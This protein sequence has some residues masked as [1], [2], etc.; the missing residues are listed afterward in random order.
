V[1]KFLNL[2]AMM[3]KTLRLTLK[4]RPEI[5]SELL[6]LNPDKD[7]RVDIS[8]WTSMRSHEQNK[9]YWEMLGQL[10]DHLGYT[11]DEMHQML[12][13][14]YLSYKNVVM[15]NEVVVVPSTT[16]LTI[17][18]FAEYMNNVENFASSLGFNFGD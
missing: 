16:S 9:R 6:K 15:D 10:G 4:S 13:Y 17:K 7:W 14:K 12:A 18:E 3:K 11:A 1:V 5:I 2:G 8:P